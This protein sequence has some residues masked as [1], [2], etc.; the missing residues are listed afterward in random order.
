MEWNDRPSNKS[1]RWMQFESQCYLGSTMSDEA[2]FRAHY[3]P[4]SIQNR[5]DAVIEIREAFY[6]SL[7]LREHRV[8]ALDTLVGQSH[9]NR[10]VQGLSLSG[11][12]INATSHWHVWTVM[13]EGH[14]EPVEPPTL[15][16]EEAIAYFCNRVNLRLNGDFKHPMHGH[17]GQL[18]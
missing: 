16:V 7:S 15:Q 4:A 14:V 13:G 18:L 9:K 10:V 11:I 2:T 1:P 3:R 8:A 5:G 6:V 17:T 12:T